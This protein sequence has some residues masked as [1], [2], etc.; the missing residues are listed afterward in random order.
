MASSN[1]PDQL[2]DVLPPAGPA[3]TRYRVDFERLVW[4][5]L[6][7]LLRR[8]RQYAWLRTLTAPVRRLYY[9]FVR[10]EAK[11]RR[12]LSY[13]S[14]V[15]SFEA[16]LND[17]YDPGPRRIRLANSDAELSPV[18]VNFVAEQQPNPVAWFVGEGEA[19]LYLYSQAAFN[20]QVDFI[21]TAPVVL[22]PRA[23]QLHAAIR[24][25]K[26]ATKKYQLRFT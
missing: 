8:P 22:R 23:Q 20:S 17:T 9:D 18:Y 3:P 4:L 6:P 14:Q 16:Y 26:L 15:L 13:T 7:A 21:V 1:L 12:E 11:T 10:F 25:L 2:P 24:H 5:L 19:P